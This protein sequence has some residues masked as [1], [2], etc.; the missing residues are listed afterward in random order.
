M[1]KDSNAKVNNGELLHLLQVHSFFSI[2]R[3]PSEES[4]AQTVT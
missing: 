2:G 1:L 3:F 4:E